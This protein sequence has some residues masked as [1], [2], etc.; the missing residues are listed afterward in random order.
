LTFRNN[1]HLRYKADIF[2]PCG[3]RPE[4]INISNVSSLID[5]DGKPHYKYIVEGANLFIAQSSRL[6]LESRGVVLYKDSSANKGGVSCSSLE[7]LA[8]LALSD[9]EHTKL[10]TFPDGSPTD[11]Y[12]NYVRDVQARISENASLEFSCIWKE[13]FRLAGSKAA[14]SRTLLSDLLSESINTLTTDLETSELFDDES[15]RNA[16]LSRAVPPTLLAKVPLSELKKRLP[17]P[18]QRALFSSFMASQFI[19]RYGINARMVQFYQFA[20]GLSSA[21]P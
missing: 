8:G 1:A 13:H 10:M 5:S 9:E 15:I 12:A 14:G 11:F 3:G 2:V 19:Y 20:H 6:F 18:Y 4:A 16:V 17:E 7:V 21:K